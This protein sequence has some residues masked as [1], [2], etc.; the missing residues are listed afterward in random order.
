VLSSFQLVIR[1]LM[2]ILWA[3]GP[4]PEPVNENEAYKN[5][6]LGYISILVQ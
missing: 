2:N 4:V 5:V 1:Y 6:K 3:C